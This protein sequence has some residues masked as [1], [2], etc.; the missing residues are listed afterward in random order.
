LLN[1]SDLSRGFLISVGAL[2]VNDS[3]EEV[4]TGLT[5]QESDFFL[6]FQERADP[7]ERRIKVQQY[8]QLME[9]HLAARQRAR[10]LLK[11]VQREAEGRR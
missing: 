9:R 4:L 5:V 6:R 8:Y 3:G 1:L 11:L 10:E 2:V 7:R